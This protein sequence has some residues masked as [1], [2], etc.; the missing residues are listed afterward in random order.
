MEERWQAGAGTGQG[1]EKKIDGADLLLGGFAA[2]RDKLSSHSGSRGGRVSDSAKVS[3][4]RRV[5]S[6]RASGSGSDEL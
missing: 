4:S 6:E 5:S 2:R 3:D 1:K